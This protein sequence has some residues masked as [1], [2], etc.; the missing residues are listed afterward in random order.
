MTDVRVY[1]CRCFSEVDRTVDLERIQERLLQNASVASSTIVDSLCLDS[2]IQRVAA[3]IKESGAERVVIAAC[4]T[5]G[6]GDSV[7]EGL[8]EEGVDRFAIHLIDI[9]EGCAW[10]HQDE[11][12]GATFKAW[13]LIDMG[14]SLVA[15]KD[16]SDDVT[17]RVRPEVL[18]I[19]AGPAGLAAAVMVAKLGY[20][21]HCLD[22]AAHPGGMLRF[23]SRSYPNDE[24]AVLKLAP[25]LDEIH[26]NARIAFYPQAR[27]ETVTGF[28]GNFTVR[29]SSGGQERW[30]RPGAIIIATGAMVYLP[31]GLYRYGET[32][33]IITQME[34]ERRLQSE[35]DSIQNAVFV[36]CVGARIPERPYC[37]TICCPASI[38]NAMRIVEKNPDARVSIVHR[39]IMMP[40]S[41]LE[42]YYRRAMLQGVQFVRYRDDMLPAIKGYEQVRA[43]EV[44]DSITGTTRVLDADLVVLSTPLVPNPDNRYLADMLGLQCDRYGFFREIYPL[45]PLETRMEGIF[46]CGSARWPVSSDQAIVQGEAAAMKVISL[47]GKGEVAASSFSRVPGQKFG[48]ATV[49][50]DRCTGCGN[51]VAV[52]P[53]DACTLQEIEEKYTYISR[54]N[55][56]RCKAC[57]NCVA[58]C[59]NGAM[60][61]PEHNYRAVVEMIKRAF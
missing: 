37:S 51:C 24:D 41:I 28:A 34:L 25:Y 54:V 15:K 7:I 60:Q 42:D 59:L 6:R 33:N 20:T 38:K 57:G 22:R 36:Q 10:I 32:Q 26:N 39:D 2:D 18:I 23:I 47:L 40:G 3:E 56:M 21:V 43:V 45:H 53:F 30:I 48:H 16:R 35:S 11:P 14:V 29:F 52:C 1:L 55:K 44:H 17:I 46:I 49:N 5:M 19:G 8:A 12:E 13:N 61:V 58:V 50:P 31:H 4:S 27:V 9:R